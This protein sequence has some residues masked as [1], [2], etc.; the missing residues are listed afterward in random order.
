M[1]QARAALL[2]L[3]ID[4]SVRNKADLDL[5]DEA[6]PAFAQGAS[7]SEAV[8]VLAGSFLLGARELHRKIRSR[9]CGFPRFFSMD[10]TYQT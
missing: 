2:Q 10:C 6:A 9:R 7:A 3:R 4:P 1:R 5:C 8:A